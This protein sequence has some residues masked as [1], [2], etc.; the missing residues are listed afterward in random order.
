MAQLFL[1]TVKELQLTEKI[2]LNLLAYKNDPFP[3]TE[4]LKQFRFKVYFFYIA[5]LKDHIGCSSTY[6]IYGDE[7][8][9]K[10]G[11]LM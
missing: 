10:S 9:G 11:M 3:S 6:L 1:D 4:V 8:S 7:G 5:F 2:K